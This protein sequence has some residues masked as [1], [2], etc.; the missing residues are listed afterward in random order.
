MYYESIYSDIINTAHIILYAVSL[1]LGGYTL[2][3]E[4]VC[5]WVCVCD[6]YIIYAI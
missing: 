5:M 6:N 2:I 4:S 1:R 3:Y